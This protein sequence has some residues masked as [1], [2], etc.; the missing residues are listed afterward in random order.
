MLILPFIY[1]ITNQQHCKLYNIKLLTIGGKYIWSE[2][3]KLNIHKDI[4]EP[5]DIYCKE[6]IDIIIDN[7]KTNIKNNI[8]LCNIDINKTNIKDFYEWNEI[9]LE[10]ET[11]FCWRNFVYILGST[12]ESW[13][14]IPSHQKLSNIPLNNL[15][16]K[17]VKEIQ[18]NT[19]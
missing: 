13:L 16:E 1:K 19:K 18:K 8:T 6:Q 7:I 5:N 3:D 17:I 12:N 14:D 15:I 2:D 10:D 11:T 4:L 9:K